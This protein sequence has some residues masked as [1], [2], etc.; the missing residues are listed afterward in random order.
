MKAYIEDRN[1]I[2]YNFRRLT[3]K[4]ITDIF[5]KVKNNGD[6]FSSAEEQFKEAFRLAN[7][8]YNMDLFEEEIMN[9]NYEELGYVNLI[10]LI[11]LVVE[12]VFH[13]T[14]TNPSKYSFLAEIKE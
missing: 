2:R 7:P 12:E 8:S 6:A 3:R 13:T 1:G 10:K 11:S 4:E 9:Y 14:G 5:S